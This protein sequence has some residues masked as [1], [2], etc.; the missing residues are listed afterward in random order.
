MSCDGSN[1]TVWNAPLLKL[2]HSCFRNTVVGQLLP[3]IMKFCCI[4]HSL[5]VC[6]SGIH[7]ILQMHYKTKHLCQLGNCEVGSSTDAFIFSVWKT[8]SRGAELDVR[9]HHASCIDL[10][11]NSSFLSYKSSLAC[12]CEF[13]NIFCF[14]LECILSKLQLFGLYLLVMLLLLSGSK[15]LA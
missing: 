14:T 5:R 8:V 6:I 13:F 2:I 15:M 3:R 7:S 10:L 4:L 1:A 9:S 12:I 11:G